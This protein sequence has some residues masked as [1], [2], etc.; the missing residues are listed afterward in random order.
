M[1]E[2]SPKWN[3]KPPIGFFKRIF[4]VSGRCSLLLREAEKA[5]AQAGD[6]GPDAQ[7]E[8]P[9]VDGRLNRGKLLVGTTIFYEDANVGEDDIRLIAEGGFDFLLSET[10]GDCQK[11]LTAWCEKYGL[12]LISKDESLPSGAGIPEALEKGGDLFASYTPED[13]RVGDTA[14]DEPHASL[15]A[16]WGEYYRLYSQRFPGKFL[17]CNLFPAGTPA[18]KLGAENYA[19]YIAEFVEKVPADFIS[20]D[21]YP[22]FS[23]ALLKG[24]AF[25]LCLHTYD[26][27]A[28]A[29][30]ES[31]RD[32]WLYLQ[33]QGNW[34]DGIY[35]L[36][37]YGQIR[38]QA[39]TALAYGAK[40][41]MHV[42]Y[43]PVWGSDAYAMIDRQ[44]RVT[45]QYL[46]A[47]RLNA[48]LNRLSPAYMK[49]RSLGVL[50]AQAKRS[51]GPMRSALRRQRKSSLQKGFAGIGPVCGVVTESSALAGYFKQREGPG[52]ALMLVDC[53][54]LYR[55]GAKQDV[56]VELAKPCRVRLYRNGAP[57]RTEEG[58]RRF[59]V[60]LAAGEGA[61][62]EIEEE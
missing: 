26:V 37:S 16:A 55:P 41:L 22:F 40:C 3:L 56:S 5:R 58:C 31:G 14:G 13:I 38:W 12:A 29:C 28:S 9:I 18:K 6:F 20:V 47:R 27:V 57:A 32:F 61:F 34:F 15:Y 42:S 46:Y 45:E 36:P 59:T 4:P 8:P 54:G 19:R 10:G 43:S 7:K 33:T 23:I 49:Y 53:A 35:A 25:R 62:D 1:G 60:T 50:P 39:Y 48:E 2:I 44:G 21:E 24:L 52:F 30:R 17:F 11:R 51:G